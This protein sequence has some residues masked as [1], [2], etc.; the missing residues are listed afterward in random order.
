[1][2]FLLKKYEVVKKQVF[3]LKQNKNSDIFVSEQLASKGFSEDLVESALSEYKELGGSVNNVVS[4][5]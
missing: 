3:L 5:K 4:V 1:M 2:V